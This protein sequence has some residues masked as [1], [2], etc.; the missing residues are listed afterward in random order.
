M[1]AEVLAHLSKA[2]PVMRQL[3][4]RVGPLTLQPDK[5]RTPFQ[6]LVRAVANQQLNG[7]AAETILG[8]F[9]AL[10]PGRRFPLPEDLAGVD[11]DR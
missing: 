10:F 7:K 9:I 1:S 8:R 5:R 6:S 2:D 11:D 4:Q 3:V